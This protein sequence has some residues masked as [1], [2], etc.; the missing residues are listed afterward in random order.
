MKEVQEFFDQPGINK[1]GIC[2]E[3]GIN[4]RFL[5]MMLNGDQRMTEAS[6]AKLLPV[7]EN[8]K[9]VA[10]KAISF[11]SAGEERKEKDSEG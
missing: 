3:A 5:N 2:K 4:I 6:K 9:Q 11:L 7:I 8:Q 1:S 10:E